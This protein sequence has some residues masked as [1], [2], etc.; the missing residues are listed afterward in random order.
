MSMFF[1]WGAGLFVCLRFCIWKRSYSKKQAQKI[2]KKAGEPPKKMSRIQEELREEHRWNNRQNQW[3]EDTILA[4]SSSVATNGFQW[5]TFQVLDWRCYQSLPQT[6]CLPPPLLFFSNMHL[7]STLQIQNSMLPKLRLC[8][9]IH[10]QG[11]E[12]KSNR[13]SDLFRLYWRDSI[14]QQDSHN[15]CFLIV[16]NRNW[17][18]SQI[19]K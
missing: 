17:I 13:V 15:L 18:N 14:L 16:K 5:I 12:R 8:V 19:G 10:P 11:M 4:F 2:D 3:G 9:C 6:I 1:C 7:W